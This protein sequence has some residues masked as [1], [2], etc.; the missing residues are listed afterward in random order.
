MR[1]RPRRDSGDRRPAND[2]RPAKRDPGAYIGRLPERE[3]ETIPGGIGRRDER[4]SSVATQPAPV[5][6][7][8]PADEQGTPPEGHREPTMDRNEIVKEAGEHR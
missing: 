4:I 5:R 3:A 6:G 1:P 8:V 2:R 7:P